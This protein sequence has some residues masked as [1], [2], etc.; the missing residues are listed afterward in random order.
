VFGV[1]TQGTPPYLLVV[2]ENYTTGSLINSNQIFNSATFTSL[3][4]IQ[5]TYTYTWGSGANADEI[6][7]IVGNGG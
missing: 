2:P 4:L 5:G 3:G 6:N 7:V 1:I